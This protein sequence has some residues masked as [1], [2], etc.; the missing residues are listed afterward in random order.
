M[1][2]QKD[3]REFIELL[4][5]HKVEFPVVGG[6]AVGFHGYPR[7]TRDINFLVRPTEE[8]AS[9]IVAAIEA[10]GFSDTQNHKSTLALREKVVQFGRPPNRIDIQTRIAILAYTAELRWTLVLR[11]NTNHLY[12]TP[13]AQRRRHSLTVMDEQFGARRCMR[14]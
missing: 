8:N 13:N 10:F 11:V 12:D 1:K 4:N 6:H 7:Y 9:R 14:I 3:L 2:L 5:S